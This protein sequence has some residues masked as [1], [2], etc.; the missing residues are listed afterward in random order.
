MAMLTA[1]SPLRQALGY[2]KFIRAHKTILLLD[3]NYHLH[4]E[5]RAALTRLG[6]RVITLRIG[7]SDG[8]ADAPAAMRQLLEAMLQ[9]KPDMLL[10]INHIG[11]DAD[12]SMGQ[13]LDEIQMPVAV[14][15]VDSPFLLFDGYFLPAAKVSSVF[16]W[17][18]QCVA[19]LRA[20][21]A[22]HVQHLP[23]GCDLEKFA[24]PQ[25]TGLCSARWPVSFV[26]NSMVY[27]EQKWR[28]LLLRT[29]V[30]QGKAWAA[31]LAAD[32]QPYAALLG[33]PQPPRD[34]RVTELAYATWVGTGLYRQRYLQALAKQTLHV[35]GD[36]GWAK[37]LPQAHAHPHVWYG[38][39]LAQVYSQSLCSFNATSL[40][41]PTAVNQ[42]VFDVP[43]AGGLVL[44]DAQ[45][46]VFELFAADEITVYRSPEE[47]LD[48][49]A[50]FSAHPT[51]RLQRIA[52]GQARVAREHT[53]DHRLRTLLDCMQAR[54]APVGTVGG[55][56]PGLH[57]AP[58]E[59]SCMPA[60][61]SPAT[62][63]AGPFA[64][65]QG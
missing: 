40:Q 45:A 20:C 58:P 49:V 15:Y 33:T 43:T 5:C 19:T 48:L 28:K 1:H 36:A 50:Y 10:T 61:R 24:P 52:K 23:L 62:A 64:G 38:A 17:E 51:E 22:E 9:H 7:G 63:S 65:G 60:G 2:R 34:R 18:R 14:W 46:D 31:Q 53:Y 47:L 32:R 3:S 54:W 12:N 41:M 29:E 42:R 4:A 13:L 37:V 44:T 35:F 6:H 16:V 27:A 26:G 8:A 25:A 11:F 39:A 59:P 30:K 55:P 57:R 56:L 21:G